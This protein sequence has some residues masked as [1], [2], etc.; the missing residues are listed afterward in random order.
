MNARQIQYKCKFIIEWWILDSGLPF[1][2]LNIT[3]MSSTDTRLRVQQHFNVGGETSWWRHLP[4][5]P[6][7]PPPRPCNDLKHLQRPRWR[8]GRR[9][10]GPG[11]KFRSYLVGSP[12]SREPSHRRWYLGLG[13]TDC[14]IREQSHT[15]ICRS[16][17]QRSSLSHIFLYD[18]SECARC[19]SGSGGCH[20]EVQVYQSVAT[21]NPPLVLC[22]RK[23]I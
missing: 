12:F 21:I 8:W 14:I 23:G 3:F 7:V 19:S 10:R 15:R 5:P 4:S 22:H 17:Q 6:P 16:Q 9:G 18:Q 2:S 20:N 11:D 13:D 1:L